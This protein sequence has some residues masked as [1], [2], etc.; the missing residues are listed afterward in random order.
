MKTKFFRPA[1]AVA[2][3]LALA[4]LVVNVPGIAAAL[5]RVFGYVPEVGLVETTNG[6]RMLA[7]PVSST[8]DG[9]TL[10]ITN[11]FA[12]PD[13]VELQYEVSGIAPENDGWQ[14]GESNTNPTAF[15]GGVN[16]GSTFSKA[17]DARLRLPDGSIL[18]REYLGKYP[19]NAFAMQPVYDTGLPADVTTLTFVLDCIPQARLGAVPEHWEL[20]F[21]LVDVPAG[22]VVGE[23]VTEV[24]QPVTTEEIPASPLTEPVSV[25]KV[26]MT[27]ERIVP[28]ET[29]TII[30]LHFNMENA[31]PSLK[32][33][34][35]EGSYMNA[36]VIDS[37]GQKI[38]LR[39]NFALQPS[40]HKVGS[41]F[42]YVTESKP[43]E[44][45]LTV[46]VDQV[47]AYYAPLYTNP[48]LATP[49]EMTFTFDAG[50]NPQHGQEWDVNA[51]FTIAGF[52][53]EVDYVKAVSYVDIEPLFDGS[54]GYE[55]G[56]QFSIKAD[57]SLGMIVDMDIMKDNCWLYEEK[58]LLYTQLCKDA[59]PSGQVPVTISRMSIT[60]LD[61]IQAEWKP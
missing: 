44:G 58:P 45:A 56:Y 30:Y 23:P 35:P 33:I 50:E 20:S 22:M 52:D 10:T 19:K 7:E 51:P 1:W 46:V 6:L 17:G 42:E 49:E 4:V 3:V 2:F 9:V 13:H 38:P 34:L 36:Y 8:R 27:L 59:Y 60:I 18:E 48:P 24:P 41:A 16:P 57:P 47:I 11:V 43:A 28:M 39:G 55:Y 37:L 32:S 31:D 25:P 26:T 53:F 15:C 5:G 61:D 12:Y 40:D 54:Q 14:S 21:N 29:N